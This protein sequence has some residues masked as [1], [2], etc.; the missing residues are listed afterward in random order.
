MS[1]IRLVFLGLLA[2]LAVSAVASGS[3][4]AA[5]PYV[6]A[7]GA[8][9]PLMGSLELQITQIGNAVLNGTLAGTPVEII[10]GLGNSKN[11]TLENV[12]TAGIEHSLGSSSI[13]YT[14]CSVAKP[15]G[16]GCL[17]Q[18]ELV[19]ATTHSLTLKGPLVLFSAETNNTFTTITLDGCSAEALNKGFKVEGAASAIP[20][21]ANSTLEFTL[22]SGSALKFGGNA[23]TFQATYKIEMLGGGELEI[24]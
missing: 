4:S 2:V 1:R 17:V 15:A 5:G 6:Y 14:M 7:K 22:T 23:A 3:A 21:N 18:N 13:H 19:L 20:N 8:A 10:C 11:S 16:K 24:K 12:L 9:N